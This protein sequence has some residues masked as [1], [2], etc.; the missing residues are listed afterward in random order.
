M[1]TAV[2][3]TE[4]SI[5]ARVKE[6]IYRILG[7]KVEDIELKDSFEN[8]LA[9]DS[10]DIVEIVMEVEEQFE[11]EIKDEDSMQFHTPGDIVNHLKTRQV[12]PARTA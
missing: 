5:I 4:D 7:T 11:V 2:M 10:L 12:K 1:N 3:D 6:C 9:A 8:D